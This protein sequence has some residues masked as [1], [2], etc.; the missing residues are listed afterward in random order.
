M[1]GPAASDEKVEAGAPSPPGA[2][3]KRVMLGVLLAAMIL[4]VLDRQVINVLAEPIRRELNLSDTQLGLLTGLAFAMFYSLVSLPLGRLVD[5]LRSNRITLVS[6]SLAVWSGMT[7]LSGVAQSFS[8]LLMAR[9]GLAVGEA[10]LVPASHSLI[11]DAYP[12]R[13]RARA[14]AVFGLGVPIGALLGKSLGGVLADTY[15]WRTAIMLVGAPGLALAMLLVMVLRDPRRLPDFASMA[16]PRVPLLEVVRDVCASRALVNLVLG[17]ATA[18][19]LVTGGS[20]WG[21]IHFQRNHGLTPGEAGLWIGVSGGVAGVLGTILGGVLADRG[22]AHNP[23]R[24]MTAPIV[25]MLLSAPLL[26]M[27]WSTHNWMLAIVLL[28]LPDLL[29]NLYYGGAYAALQGLVSQRIRATAT[30]GLI[31]VSTLFGTGLGSLTFGAASDA[32]TPLSG[33]GESVR[34]VL[35][36]AALLYVVPAW[37]YWRASR[38]LRAEFRPS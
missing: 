30:A 8:H 36:G 3:A 12:V 10:G 9:I 17:V 34:W 31:F 37:F 38:F 4:N 27:A 18:N 23:A 5:N 35:M 2:R 16:S 21:M 15:G 6:A 29:D 1:P 24:Y 22:G 19:F 26:V 28:F 20:V 25:G 33:A 14:L 11:A 7:V 32:L 13:R